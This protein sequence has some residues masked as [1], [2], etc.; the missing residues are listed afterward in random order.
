[1]EIQNIIWTRINQIEDYVEKNGIES[2]DPYDGIFSKVPNALF[3]KW[4]LGLR[5]WQQAVRLSPFEIRP[6]IG[7]PKFDHTKTISDFASAYA[8]LF[9]ITQD[10]K[11]YSLAHQML[12]W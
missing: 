5:L 4:K 12:E 6:M 2:F 9:K 11:Y 3:G 1:M 7:V 10:D 8:L